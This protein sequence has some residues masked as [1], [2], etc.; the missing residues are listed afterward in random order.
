M[1]IDSGLSISKYGNVNYLFNK[2]LPDN[3]E[4]IR[5]VDKDWLRRNENWES[6]VKNKILRDTVTNTFYG[7]GGNLTSVE[8]LLSVK[9]SSTERKKPLDKKQTRLL[10]RVSKDLLQISNAFGLN[11]SDLA[12]IVKVTRPTVYSWMQ[13]KKI[14]RKAQLNRIYKLY[15]L[16]EDWQQN[17]FPVNKELLERSIITSQSVID[18]LCA[19]SLDNKAIIA[20]GAKLKLLS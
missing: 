19:D 4:C 1:A 9:K 2:T 18:L 6:L 20:A 10:S 12:K 3:Q 11:K 8:N 7:L 13:G 5:I 14:P 17:E 16:A 15:L